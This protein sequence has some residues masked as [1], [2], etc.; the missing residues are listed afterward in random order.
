[1]IA[2]GTGLSTQNILNVGI[3]QAHAIPITVPKIAP[4][5]FH[6]FLIVT[7]SSIYG[8]FAMHREAGSFLASY[9]SFPH[10]SFA[11]FP[12]WETACLHRGRYLSGILPAMISRTPYP[13]I[14]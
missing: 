2:R 8:H 11:C 5:Y 7:S 3:H 10:F 13:P 6:F 9:V 12:Q 14:T 1:M 4:T